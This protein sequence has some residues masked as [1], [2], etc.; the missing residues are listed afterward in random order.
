MKK[1][2]S[3][4][5]ISVLL[6]GCKVDIN[7]E[8]NYADIQSLEHKIISSD[9]Y[10]EVSSCK[11]FEDSRQESDSLIR[12]KKTV[13]EVF[14]NAEY[15]EC[16]EKRMDSYAH[17]KVPVGVGKFAEGAKKT[18]AELYLYSH[19]DIL[20]GVFMNDKLIAKIKQKEKEAMTSFKFNVNLKINGDKTPVT[21]YIVSSY[22]AD[23]SEAL[24][25][26]P[27][28]KYTWDGKQPVTYTLSNVSV[29]SLMAQGYTPVMM[30]PTY[31]K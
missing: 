3:V 9:V 18:D 10:F 15:V 12:L 13:P 24:Y 29:D 25:P 1:V 8:A 11:N 4:V 27:I 14:S 31:F 22:A 26:V 5:A 2:I 21:S 30:S 17:Y 19:G 28:A 7:T 23:G 16:F 6:A 20:V